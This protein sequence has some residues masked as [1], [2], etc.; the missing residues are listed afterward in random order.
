MT[1]WATLDRVWTATAKAP[2]TAFPAWRTA[3]TPWRRIA[4]GSRS[5]PTNKR[6]TWSTIAAT[7]WTSDNGHAELLQ[8]TE[9]KQSPN[10]YEQA[11]QIVDRLLKKRREDWDKL[12]PTYYLPYATD[13]SGLILIVI[14]RLFFSKKCEEKTIRFVHSIAADRTNGGPHQKNSK[15]TSAGVYTSTSMW[16]S[17]E[18]KIWNTHE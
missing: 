1:W 7:V 15:T 6:W 16:R 8:Q 5:E 17:G 12:L 11:R 4:S 3:A 9:E 2:S 10:W 14:V 13:R 18:K